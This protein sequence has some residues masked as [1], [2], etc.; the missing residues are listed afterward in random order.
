VTDK[1]KIALLCGLLVI[2]AVVF[3][4]DTKGTV[5][6]RP[7]SVHTLTFIPLPVENPRLRRDKLEASRK[8]EYKAGGRDLFTEGLVATRPA[9]AIPK[10]DPHPQP[11]I[12]PP[13]P[14]PTLPVKFFGYGT[15]PN[16]TT[17]RAFLTDGE[18]IYIVGE[19]DTLLGRFRILKIG[20]ASLDFEELTTGRRNSATLEEQAA[21][22][23]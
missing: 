7:G 1:R 4:F 2:V 20:N 16:G 13:E 21:P 14:P 3:Y 5:I 10:P 22:P 9:P 11:I 17:K 6:T 23:A 15:I 18:E 19:G 12:P 8:T